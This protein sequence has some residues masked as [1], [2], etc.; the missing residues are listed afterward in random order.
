MPKA[1]PSA[2]PEIPTKLGVE[3]TINQGPPSLL[4]TANECRISCLHRDTLESLL[5]PQEPGGDA[6]PPAWG[7]LHHCP[8]PALPH[9]IPA[10]CKHRYGKPSTQTL[11]FGQVKSGFPV[12][13]RTK[14]QHSFAEIR[15]LQ[16]AYVTAP[17]PATAIPHPPAPCKHTSAGKQKVLCTEKRILHIDIPNPKLF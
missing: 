13:P 10:A 2:W 1:I 12:P 8:E 6:L 16:S 14:Y 15:S 9:C 4:S 11:N 17:L 5:V 7:T 3:R